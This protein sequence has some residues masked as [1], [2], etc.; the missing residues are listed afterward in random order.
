MQAIAVEAPQRSEEWFKQRLGRV[1][2]S[3]VSKIRSYYKPAKYQL[4]KLIDQATEKHTTLGTKK[5][6]IKRLAEEYPIELILNAG[7]E[8]AETVERKKYRQNKVGERL[9]GMPA[10]PEPYVNY[11]MKWG[12]MN[13]DFAKSLYQMQN[14][15]IVEEAPLLLHPK[16]ACGASSDG[17]VT[18]MTTGEI[19]CVEVKCLRTA[20]H[21][22]EIIKEEKVPDDYYDQIQMELWINELNWCDFIGFDS[23]VG[24]GLK[25]FVERVYPDKLFIEHVLEP[26]VKRFLKECDTDEKFFRAKLYTKK[27]ESKK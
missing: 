23:R 3:E 16:L 21:L 7:M 27:R 14:K 26:S 10:D 8:L 6:V 15:M 2:G 17:H 20:N 1:T 12:M 13:E 22:Y 4:P 19:G 11:D 24:D 9:T 18:D 5:S 25:I